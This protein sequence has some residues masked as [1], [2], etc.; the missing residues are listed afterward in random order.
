MSVS[1]RESVVSATT[2]GSITHKSSVPTCTRCNLS[3]TSGHAYELGSDRWHTHCF[4]CYKCDKKLTC[5]SD[6]LVL[7]TGT[8]I[9]FACSDSC[10][11]CNKKIDDLAIILSSSNEAY[12]SDCFKCYKCGKKIEDLRYAKTRKGLFCIGCHEQLMAKRKYAEEK[13]R[14]LRKE[15]PT[16]PSQTSLS[17][18]LY[19]LEQESP[20]KIPP[21]KS[22][23]RQ[24]SPLRNVEHARARSRRGSSASENVAVVG[25]SH[26][27]SDKNIRLTSSSGLSKPSPLERSKSSQCLATPSVVEVNSNLALLGKPVVDTKEKPVK[28]TSWSV[29][30]QFLEDDDEEQ[31]VQH[32]NQD[33]DDDDDDDDDENDDDDTSDYSKSRPPTTISA[34]SSSE[35]LST[36][37]TVR[38]TDNT[39]IH[40]PKNEIPMTEHPLPLSPSSAGSNFMNKIQLS[41][42]QQPSSPQ[43][44]S[45]VETPKR[46]HSRNLSV[47]DV[48]QRTLTKDDYESANTSTNGL[49]LPVDKSKKFLLNRTPLRNMEDPQMSRSPVSHRRGIIMSESGDFI[50]ELLSSPTSLELMSRNS[51]SNNQTDITELQSS[52]MPGMKDVGN[53]SESLPNYKNFKVSVAPGLSTKMDLDCSPSPLSSNNFMVHSSSSSNS[54]DPKHGRCLSGNNGNTNGGSVSSKVGSKLARSASVRSKVASLIHGKKNTTPTRTPQHETGVFETHTGWGVSSIPQQQQQQQQTLKPQNNRKLPPHGRGRSDSTIYS[55]LSP[56]VSAIPS[57]DHQ[58]SYSGN[59]VAANVA[60]NTTPPLSSHGS[61]YSENLLA[62]RKIGDQTRFSNR[63]LFP[64]DNRSLTNEEFLKRDLISEELQLRQIRLEVND[65][66]HTKAQLMID[67]DQLRKLKDHLQGKIDQLN[68]ERKGFHA[69][70]ASSESLEEVQEAIVKQVVTATTSS[71]VKPRFWKLFGGKPSSTTTSNSNSATSS[72]GQNV[73]TGSPLTVGISHPV[74]QNPNEFDEWNLKSVNSGSELYGSTLVSRVAYEATDIPMIIK[75]CMRHIESKVVYLTSEGIYRKSGSQLL[76]EQIENEFSQWKPNTPLPDRLNESL[77]QDIHAVSGVLKRYLRKLPNPLFTFEIYEALMSFVRDQKLCTTLSLKNPRASPIY[78][79]LID[80]LVVILKTL[81]PEHLRVLKV[82]CQHINRVV[83]YQDVNL[84]NIN[85]LALV[86]APGMIRDYTGEK[87]ISDMKERN[88]L[89]GFIFTT[90]EDIFR[91]DANQQT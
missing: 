49:E 1:Q 31:Q 28:S 86:F 67:V 39:K 89:V 40:T 74:L 38:M 65:L 64:S 16:V 7:G 13:R 47:D 91:E 78:P 51:G 5:D 52:P 61:P 21:A 42:Q 87:D 17:G 8:L 41:T 58:R 54:L 18:H 50:N 12:C 35:K 3:I 10:K 24:I 60:I 59:V 70:T 72:S 63:E 11:G 20:T 46:Q 27:T 75:T 19:G 71:N 83:Q 2:T 45:G 34:I 68:S 53:L 14:R 23:H 33:D 80:K 84:M 26:K 90:Y 77:N 37:S 62:E 43:A 25:D 73:S 29:V 32:H 79:S 82:I 88:Y 30:A 4:T 55:Q 9:C 44:N 76:I 66:Q 69:T 81:P 6:F 56:N 15:L 57:F 85:N 22:A 48:L 36:I